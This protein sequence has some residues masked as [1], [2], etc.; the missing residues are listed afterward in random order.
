MNKHFFGTSL[1]FLLLVAASCAKKTTAFSSSSKMEDF[2]PVAAE[3][4]Y[5]SAKAK[6]VIEEESGKVTRGTVNFRAKKDSVL[7]FTVS[8]GMGVEAFRGFITQEKIMIKDRIGNDDINMSYSEFKTIFGLTLSLELFQNVLWANTPHPFDYQDRLARVGDSFELT[9]V[10]NEVRYFS[11]IDVTHG[12]V[13]ELVSNSIDDRGSL[14]ASFPNFQDIDSQ[15]FPIDV[16]FKL[17]YQTDLGSQN[18]IIN[19][20]WV[21]ITPYND[22]MTFPF[23]F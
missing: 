19:L 15:P 4:D 1:I 14:L 13:S 12:K 18:T 23:R 8:P 17:A 20:E 5:L 22:P 7:W 3:Y 9:Q 2:N 11:K 21:S 16:L 6:I 10:R